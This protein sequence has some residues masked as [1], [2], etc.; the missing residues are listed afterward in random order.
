MPS[1]YNFP[2]LVEIDPQATFPKSIAERLY[3]ILKFRVLTGKLAPSDRIVE[4]DI[5]AEFNVS[6]TPLREAL[7]RLA[8]EGLMISSPYKGYV[9]APLT[10]ADFHEL[11]ELRRIIEPEAA[12]LAAE[13]ATADDLAAL[14]KNAVTEC[15][16]GDHSSY[17][18][19][20]RTN[21]AFHLTLIRAT[22][23]RRLERIAMAALDGH[24]RP[25]YMGLHGGM[26]VAASNEE[27]LQ[28]VAAIEAHDPKNAASLTRYHISKGEERITAALISSG[29]ASS[30]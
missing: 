17:E 12:A 28:I 7:N 16:Q 27:H 6:R 15:I 26:D 10:V 9:V 30:G 4:T 22:R 13:R 21:C 8:H 11:C 3:G 2:S 1:T 29:Y 20:L 19:F 14:R 24:Q 5:S 23:N 18:S 25:C